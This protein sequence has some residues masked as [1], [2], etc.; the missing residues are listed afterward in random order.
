M[1][2]CRNYIFLIKLKSLFLKYS[3]ED[4]QEKNKRLNI[5][6]FMGV[7]EYTLENCFELLEELRW[8]HVRQSFPTKKGLILII[9][10]GKKVKVKVF[11]GEVE[12]L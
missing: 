9:Y 1:L 6:S 5:Y 11:W 12:K 7:L 2:S 3:Y 10:K 4:G 8:E